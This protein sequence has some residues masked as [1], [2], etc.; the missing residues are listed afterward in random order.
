MPKPTGLG[1]VGI[2][3]N[4]LPRMKDFYTR[5]LGLTV[6][7]ESEER[8]MVF[9]SARPEEEHHEFLLVQG[10]TAPP[11]LVHLN[12]ISF[13]A[14]SLEDLQ[15]YHR[16]LKQEGVVIEQV[17]TH[18][19]AFGIYFLDPEGNRLEV[20][21]STDVKAPQPYR[22]DLNLDQPADEVLAEAERL[23]ADTSGSSYNRITAG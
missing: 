11:G 12:Q 13:H 6:T 9:L 22:K 4:D 5:V 14:A 1:H 3:V 23:L 19:I 20:Y 17:V 2:H 16:I 7:D 15:E 10:R 21:W 18:G 8:G